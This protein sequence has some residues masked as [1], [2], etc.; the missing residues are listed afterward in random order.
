MNFIKIFLSL[1]SKESVSTIY[2]SSIVA[3]MKSFISKNKSTS[4]EAEILDYLENALKAAKENKWTRI[5]LSC[6][7]KDFLNKIQ[8]LGKI[9][10]SGDLIPGGAID[11]HSYTHIKNI[12]NYIGARKVREEVTKI[13][14]FNSGNPAQEVRIVTKVKAFEWG[15]WMSEADRTAHLF[16]FI[17]SWFDLTKILKTNYQLISF[18]SRLSIAF[19]A[20]GVKGSVAHFRPINSIS[21]YINLNKVDGFY[22]LGH[23]WAHAFDYFLGVKLGK[24]FFT[25]LNT[26]KGYK[27]TQPKE[28]SHKIYFLIEELF[29]KLY[30]K[31]DKP[32][33]FQERLKKKEEYYNL[34]VEVWARLVEVFFRNELDRLNITNN[35]L[36]G[37]TKKYK[38]DQYLT[39]AEL[40]PLIPLIRKI[41]DLGIK[42]LNSKTKITSKNEQLSG[43]TEDAVK[44]V[45]KVNDFVAAAKTVK[46]RINSLPSDIA[47]LIKP[48]GYESQVKN[49]TYKITGPIGEFLGKIEIK[50]VGSVVA[51]LDAEQ[52]S[53]KTR[54][55][56]QV[57]NALALSGLKGL[58]ISL[59]EH[60]ESQLIKD[61]IKSYISDEAI[62]NL[63]MVGEISGID[64]LKEFAKYF[65]FIVIDSFGKIPDSRGKLDEI[66]KSINGK[67]IMAIFQQTS[68]GAMRGGSDSAF[69]ADQIMKI[70]KM[71]DYR[72]SYVYHNK[73]RYQD[74][75]LNEI[76]FRIYDQKI[77]NPAKSVEE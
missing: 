45:S 49:P 40:T 1:L 5:F 30:W 31:A 26:Q 75:P 52:G 54:F 38:Q 68:N 34:R 71:D 25:T 18:N 46:S 66:R 56:F 6:E 50:P 24:R 41:F 59:E 29:E 69:D 12:K 61:K 62:G 23:E 35:Y 20:R 10:D 14:P 76:G 58:F 72:E 57:M 47:E 77:I 21:A 2:L 36:V 9:T 27:I 67:Y 73:N 4:E 19:G 33:A 11:Q 65:D 74:K 63:S 70:N 39:K 22:S 43:F 13:V 7:N 16:A 53:G 55:V 44:A 64:Q 3:R 37:T 15:R 28:G 32:T 8:S 60:P 42:E 17:L 51:T 48:I